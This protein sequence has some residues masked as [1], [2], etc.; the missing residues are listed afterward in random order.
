MTYL[1]LLNAEREYQWLL[2]KL[3]HDEWT[4]DLRAFLMTQ[5]LAAYH[6]SIDELWQS[7]HA[8]DTDE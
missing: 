8:S 5:R 6:S 2:R 4:V 3:G 1:M 7:V